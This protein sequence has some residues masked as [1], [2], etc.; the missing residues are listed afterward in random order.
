MRD[1]A[2]GGGRDTGGLEPT[3]PRPFKL[4]RYFAE[5]EFGAAHLLSSSDCESFGLEELVDLFDGETLALW[6]NLRLGYTES[7]GH[8]LLRREIA[9]LHE[10]LRPEDIVVLSPGEGILVAFAA[11][12]EA[13]DRA[14]VTFPAYQSLTELP[15]ARG[16][17]VVPWPL[18]LSGG[19][20][21]LDPGFL[22]RALGKRTRV[23][24][25]NFPHNPTG[26]HLSPE[27]FAHVVQTCEK[28]GVTLLSDE[29]YR[30]LEHDEAQRLAPAASLS[31]RCVSLSG[32][33]KSFGLPGLRIGWLAS[34]DR[35]AVE[36]FAR[37]RDYTTL[38]SSAPSEIL[39][40]GAIRARERILARNR[41]ILAENLRAAGAFFERHRELFTWT[42]PRAGPVSLA[43]LNGST[44][45]DEFCETLYRRRRVMLLPGS[46]FDLDGNFVRVGIG[47]SDLER[48]LGVLESHILGERS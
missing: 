27:G 18:E 6:K 42:P 20:W 4:E 13:G 45:A 16:C 33:S 14:V 32:L 34:R 43:R 25:V 31:P 44:P 15:A 12:L 5:R 17:E 26:F 35:G 9:S 38:C 3:R 47:R 36:S 37:I 46:V 7:A 8:P 23:V 28:H 29:M 40:I 39:A 41:G 1:S 19:R 2:V 11:L 48:G 10:G 24:A 22:D 21:E 30:F